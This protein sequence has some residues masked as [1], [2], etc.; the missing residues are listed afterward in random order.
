MFYSCS[1]ALHVLGFVG[2]QLKC[3]AAKHDKKSSINLRSS[4][5]LSWI[6]TKRKK[7]KE[8]ILLLWPC[9]ASTSQA[10][11]FTLLSLP[12]TF[13][14]HLCVHTTKEKGNKKEIYAFWCYCD[15]LFLWFKGWSFP[16]YAQVVFSE[17][18]GAADH[19]SWAFHLFH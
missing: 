16:L 9:A 14:L 12:A 17:T 6:E 1:H 11:S 10:F 4:I 15:M 13:C 8:F 5:F 18:V 3:D 7:K 19:K 2:L